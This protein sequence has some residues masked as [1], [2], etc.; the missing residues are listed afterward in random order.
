VS[1]NTATA[2]ATHTSINLAPGLDLMVHADH[3]DNANTLELIERLREILNRDELVE[4][5][6]GHVLAIVEA[7]EAGDD[8][9]GTA[10]HHILEAAGW[11]SCYSEGTFDED[12]AVLFGA[13]DAI[14]LERV[15]IVRDVTVIE[16]GKMLGRQGQNFRE[17][18]PAA[19]ADAVR[20][21]AADHVV[22]PVVDGIDFIA[23]ADADEED[24]RDARALAE[25]IRA[26]R[27]GARS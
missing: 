17:N 25:G 23:T 24:L 7:G 15:I 12:R 16:W 2:T 6:K 4:G 22:I 11:H 18:S 3:A 21:L 20:I 10:M 19:I 9:C 27:A 13:L 14:P 1:Q 26:R 8:E 5:I